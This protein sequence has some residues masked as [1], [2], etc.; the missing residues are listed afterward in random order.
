MNALIRVGSVRE[1]TI[2]FICEFK[3]MN[4]TQDEIGQY[5]GRTMARSPGLSLR[6]EVTLWFYRP[7]LKEITEKKWLFREELASH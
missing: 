2:L 5:F 3:K 7:K 4:K 6:E 1:N